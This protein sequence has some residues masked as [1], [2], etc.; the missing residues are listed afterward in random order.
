MEIQI[1]DLPQVCLEEI[2]KNLTYAEMSRLGAVCKY[3]RETAKTIFRLYF[4]HQEAIIEREMDKIESEAAKSDK[5]TVDDHLHMALLHSVCF[6]FI[7]VTL[8]PT[9]DGLS[10]LSQILRILLSEAKMLKAH[11]WR[12]MKDPSYDFCFPAGSILDEFERILS[13]IRD[14]TLNKDMEP[15]ITTTL[16]HLGETFY[17]YFDT[18]IESYFQESSKL[19]VKIVAETNRHTF[20]P[21]IYGFASNA[22][23]ETFLREIHKYIKKNQSFEEDEGSSRESSARKSREN[24]EENGDAGGENQ[25][26]NNLD[27]VPGASFQLRRKL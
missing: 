5:L 3:F 16:F 10:T 17:D 14:K 9:D 18:K 2:F 1:T 13:T 25:W 21:K 15:E 27:E 11:C 4:K 8:S 7:S 20:L 12:Y 26:R 23:K 19:Q 24:S 6:K 22:T